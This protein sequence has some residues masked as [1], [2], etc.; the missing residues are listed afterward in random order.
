M[1][2]Y[3]FFLF[4]FL[5]AAPAAYR[6]SQARGLNGAAAAGL[7][8]SHSRSELRLRPTPQLMATSDPYPTEGPG[9]EPTSSWVLV[10]LITTEPQWELQR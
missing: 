9:I 1:I 4:F 2:F 8:H 3:S 6:S 7:H 10:G 5:R